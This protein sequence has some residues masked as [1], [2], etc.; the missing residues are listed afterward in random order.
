VAHAAT[1]VSSPRARDAAAVQPS[2]PAGFEHAVGDSRRELGRAI[3]V[4][5]AT[6]SSA[7]EDGGAERPGESK[8]E[9]LA[10][11]LLAL[12]GAVDHAATELDEADAL[13]ARLRVNG[14]ELRELALDVLVHSQKDELPSVFDE[15]EQNLISTAA[16]ILSTPRRQPQPA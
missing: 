6:V 10:R 9:I 1:D 15:L 3:R 16:A 4:Y 13:A 14:L 7:L 2:T 5:H 12:A 11:A 8:L